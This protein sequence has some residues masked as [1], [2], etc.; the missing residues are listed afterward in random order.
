MSNHVKNSIGRTHSTVNQCEI[1]SQSDLE[2]GNKYV[3][4]FSFAEKDLFCA[5]WIYLSITCLLRMFSRKHYM[6]K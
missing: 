3:C 1:I 2:L 4:V 6:Q 5:L